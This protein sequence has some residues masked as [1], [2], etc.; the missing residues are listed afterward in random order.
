MT[1]PAFEGCGIELEYMVVD[2]ATMDVLPIADQVLRDAVRRQGAEAGGAV[3]PA[4]SAHPS[5]PVCDVDRGDYGWSNELVAHVLELKCMRPVADLRQL[6]AGFEAEVRWMNGLLAGHGARLMPTAMHPWMDPRRQTRLWPHDPQGIYATF[7]RIFDCRAHGWA[8]LQSMHVNLPFKGDAEFARLHEAIRIALPVLP[9][10]AASSPWSDRRAGA[11]LDM[12][13]MHYRDNARAYPS[14]TGAVVPESVDSR[15]AYEARIL[16]PMYAQIAP[17]DPQR[18]LAHEWL[19]ARGAIARFDRSAIEIRVLDVQECPRADIAVAATTCA[20]V[21]ALFDG[22]HGD[23]SASPLEAPR[24]AG[25]LQSCARDGEAAVIEDADY[26]ARLGVPAS[27]CTAAEAWRHLVATLAD[28][29]G[30]E[31]PRGARLAPDWRVPLERILRQGPLARRMLRA[32]GP[33]P[34]D[35]ALHAVDDALADCLAVGR[36]FEGLD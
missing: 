12:R 11:W 25:V 28:A 24:L 3:E 31:A 30:Q 14:I 19:N 36:M 15:A 35:G 4:G 18:V 9:A 27:R 21:K 34:S 7:D 13:L 8:N 17:V 23:A 16:Q 32:V 29:P 20:L 1:L 26:L 10:I 22:W 2:A 5:G 6:A 33:Q